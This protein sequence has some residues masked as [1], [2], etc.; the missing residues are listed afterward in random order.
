[1]ENNQYMNTTDIFNG[2]EYIQYVIEYIGDFKEQINNNKDI[3]ITA[4]DNEY[5]IASINKNLLSDYLDR[6][7]ARSILEKYL[8][9]QNLRVGFIAQPQVYTLQQISAIEAAQVDSLQANAQLN[10]NGDGVIVGIIDTGMDYLNEEFMDA[11]GNTRIDEIWD[12]TIPTL[13]NEKSNVAFGTVYTKDKINEAIQLYKSGENPYSIVPSKDENGHG[14][15]M[16][17]IIGAMGKNSNIKG[18]APKCKFV[19]VKLVEANFFKE[20]ADI[21]IPVYGLAQI[22]SAIE[23]LK[24]I[25]FNKGKPVVILLP[26][27][28]NNG[29]HKGDNLFDSYI[30]SVSRNVGIVI[31]TGA[32]NE[33]LQDGHV[34]GFIKN[35]NRL[36]SIGLLVSED[37]KSLSVEMW[38]D[39]PSICDI[40][41]TSPTGKETG[42]IQ[43]ML[44]S[45]KRYSFV[46]E[47]TTMR[48]Q[49]YLPEPFSGAELILINFNNITAGLWTLRLRIREGKEAIYNGW[50]LQRGVVSRGT[51]FT[52]SDPYGTITIPGDSDFIVTIAAYNQNNN[53]LLEYSG[54]GF[55][56]EYIDK[57]DVAAGGVNTK[58]VGL[59]NSI[60]TINGTSLSA[61]IGAGACVLLLQWGI[62]QGNYPYMYLQSIKTFIRRGVTQRAGDTYPNPNWGYGI[63][64]F[65]RLF[66]NMI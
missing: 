12:Q 53:S 39:L 7:E 25:L 5:A 36:E 56:E 60:A 55:R 51:R 61:A 42:F 29:N 59:N 43:S 45:E 4:I 48:I 1:M 23:Y 34:S 2:S 8:I 41:I 54:I 13:A 47:N 9:N 11:D 50:I 66:E 22:M 26:L 19:I 62:V 3:Y 35:K 58:T 21:K 40:S 32:G 27:G 24:K 30:E 10:L 65:Y 64:N 52:S 16:A 6:N 33:A 18:I 14:T 57:I 15:A 37:Q 46:L 49:Y 63:L 17:G 44:K 38:I 20:S 28:S 31:V